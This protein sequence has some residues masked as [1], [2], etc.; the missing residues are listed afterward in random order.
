MMS[1]NSLVTEY[2]E[3]GKAVLPLECEERAK[4][5]GESLGWGQPAPASSFE[6]HDLVE[7]ALATEYAE[8]KVE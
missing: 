2:S 8:P 7:L 3:G 4:T 6:S 5:Q 1:E